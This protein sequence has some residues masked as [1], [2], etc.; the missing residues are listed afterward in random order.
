MSKQVIRLTESE[1]HRVIEESVKSIINESPAAIAWLANKTA[2][3]TSKMATK[4]YNVLK[5]ATKANKEWQGKA[6][7]ANAFNAARNIY[8]K[9]SGQNAQQRQNPRASQPTGNQ[10]GIR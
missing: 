10:S 8:N 6:G 5:N 9:W 7:A 1:L 4:G 3:L 2:S